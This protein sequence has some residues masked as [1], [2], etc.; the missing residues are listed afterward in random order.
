MVQVY[1]TYTQSP[2]T[3]NES[4]FEFTDILLFVTYFNLLN[5]YLLYMQFEVII[6]IA[7]RKLRSIN[8]CFKLLYEHTLLM[9]IFF[10]FY[11][12][13]LQQSLTLHPKFTDSKKYPTH[14]STIRIL[15]IDKHDEHH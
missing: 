8:I 10:F 12:N 15:Y 4:F 9:A 7:F 3:F 13:I 2:L 11:L 14:A 6:Y 1:T 5:T